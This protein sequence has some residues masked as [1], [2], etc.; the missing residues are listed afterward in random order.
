MVLYGYY[1]RFVKGFSNISKPITTLQCKGIK[2]EWTNE[3]DTTFIELKRLLTSVSILRVVDMD[4]D[5]TICTDASKKALDTML[6]QD[7]E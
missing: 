7:R 5:F 6:K 4:K 3:C 2:Y 1:Q